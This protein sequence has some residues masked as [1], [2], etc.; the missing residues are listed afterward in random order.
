MI[1]HCLLNPQKFDKRNWDFDPSSVFAQIDAFVQR[2]RDLLAVCEGQFQFCRKD[3]AHNNRQKAELPAFGGI[4]K[5]S[6]FF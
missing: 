2:C 4:I 5:Q 3:Q 6:V 1:V